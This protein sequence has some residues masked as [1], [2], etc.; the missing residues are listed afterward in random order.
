MSQEHFYLIDHSFALIM[1]QF[2]LE[3][4]EIKAYVRNVKDR[5]AEPG[6]K[7]RGFYRQFSTVGMVSDSSLEPLS[8]FEKTRSKLNKKLDD[9]Q[10]DH[11]YLLF[12]SYFFLISFDN[13][14]FLSLCLIQNFMK[15]Y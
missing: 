15:F 4:D 12:L 8:S 1:L 7:L 2:E 5:I 14:R 9:I 11:W 6:N 13:N 10:A 3:V